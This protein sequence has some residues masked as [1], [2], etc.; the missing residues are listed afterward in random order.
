MEKTIHKYSSIFVYNT[1]N[2]TVQ[3][4][5]KRERRNNITKS[6]LQLS[7][8]TKQIIFLRSENLI[9]TGMILE[10]MKDTIKGGSRRAEKSRKVQMM[11]MKAVKLGWAGP[12]AGQEQGMSGSKA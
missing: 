2:T 11:M 4:P 8:I 9:S 12:G 7:H 6:K 1:F 3:L 5:L 10:A